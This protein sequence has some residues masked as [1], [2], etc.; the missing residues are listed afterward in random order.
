MDVLANIRAWFTGEREALDLARQ[1]HVTSHGTAYGERTTL[2]IDH[3]IPDVVGAQEGWRITTDHQHLPRVHFHPRARA[4]INAASQERGRRVY[5]IDL[6]S[7]E[8]V[9]AMSYHL[10]NRRKFPL[11][12]TAIGLRMDEG[13][14]EDLYDASRGA[15][16]L[17]KQY[18]HELAA[19]VGRAG[20][21]DIDADGVTALRNLSDLGFVRAPRVKGLRESGRRMRQ[22]PL[23]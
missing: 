11:M 14:P 12:L 8:V 16:F 6:A 1:V 21:V 9:A 7:A 20:Y 17:L 3:R 10:D 4:K 5:C 22:H 18:L 15:A 2:H 19:Q 13:A 23:P